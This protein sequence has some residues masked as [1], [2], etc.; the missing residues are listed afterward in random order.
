MINA[1]PLLPDAPISA[2][3][4]GLR[5]WKATDSGVGFLLATGKR[6]RFSKPASVVGCYIIRRE[7]YA[8]FYGEPSPILIGALRD[9]MI[10][11]QYDTIH[12]EVVEDRLY[13][14]YGQIIGTRFV[15][16]L[17]EGL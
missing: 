7:P 16:R 9:S 5:P 17:T 8:G 6:T 11:I 12:F 2:F 15:A 13:A 1:A 4:S 3:F 14:R 10:E